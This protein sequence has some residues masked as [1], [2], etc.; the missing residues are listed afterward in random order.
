M[1]DLSTDQLAVKVMAMAEKKAAPFIKTTGLFK[2]QQCNKNSNGVELC[3][4]F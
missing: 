4:T 1:L 2:A 3:L